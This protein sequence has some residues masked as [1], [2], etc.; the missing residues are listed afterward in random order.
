MSAVAQA[1]HSANKLTKLN[2]ESVRNPARRPQEATVGQSWSL[3]QSNF[4]T[5]P[6]ALGPGEASDYR[7]RLA[8]EDIFGWDKSNIWNFQVTFISQFSEVLSN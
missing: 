7:K 5:H 2:P 6:E 1:P 8:Q 4:Q 3:A